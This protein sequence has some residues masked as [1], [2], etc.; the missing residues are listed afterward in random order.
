MVELKCHILF[1]GLLCEGHR[2]LDGSLSAVRLRGSAGIRWSEL[3]IQATERVPPAEAKAEA[4]SQGM[5]ADLM[6]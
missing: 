2:Y 4:E 3:C 6:T 5:H 1:T